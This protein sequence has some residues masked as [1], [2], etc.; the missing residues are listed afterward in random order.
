MAYSKRSYKSSGRSFSKGG[1]YA[2]PTRPSAIVLKV[3][4]ECR[5]PQQQVICQE[6]ASGAGNIAVPSVAG[7]GK[8]ELI[9][10]A[11]SDYYQAFP[12]HTV[13]FLAFQ[14]KIGDALLSRVP[15][16]VGDVRTVHGVGFGF[17]ARDSKNSQA[18]RAYS[19]MGD[20]AWGQGRRLEV[21][22][23]THSGG[24]KAPEHLDAFFESRVG[25]GDDAKSKRRRQ[26][27]VMG[28]ETA[29]SLCKTTLT[30]I[31]PVYEGEQ[32]HEKLVRL[33]RDPAG[34]VSL[35]DKYA[36]EFS[37]E[38]SADKA[39]EHIMAALEWN[40]NG[41]GTIVREYKGKR[42]EKKALT[43]GDM[44]WL[45][46]V[47][48]WELPRYDLVCVD[49][50]QDLSPA[51]ILLAV[52]SIKA[53]GRAL[54]VGDE[55]QSIFG[56]AGADC[57]ALPKLISRLDAKILP[58]TY[59]YRCPRAVVEFVRT[60]VDAA[61]PIEA[62]PTAKDG[63]VDEADAKSVAGEAKI[64]D[65][66]ISRTNAPLVRFFFQ[67]AKAGT[68]VN[69]LGREIGGQ[70]AWRLRLWQRDAMNAGIPWTV[71]ALLESSGAYYS[72]REERINPKNRQ[73]LEA[74]ADERETIKALCEGLSADADAS[75]VENRVKRLF[76]EN[77]NDTKSVLLASTH[78]FK[79]GERER[80]FL[81]WE[82]YKFA[83]DTGGE[84]ESNEM[85]QERNLAIVGATRSLDRLTLVTGLNQRSEGE[86]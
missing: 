84:H 72:A 36:V 85:R 73:A 46:L 70:I 1:S 17:P 65:A 19:I 37:D 15:P 45:P 22:G 31:V 43:F 18:H 20:P 7:S 14:K 25:A 28:L 42:E 77:E 40:L 26:Q 78:R 79:G 41:P 30:G 71:R 13:L 16:S 38:L 74:V 6:L 3:G 2:K 39:A 47:K 53:G 69:F 35:I 55:F 51:R 83:G 52:L 8:T 56:F 63:T 5:S 82:T 58:L 57:D 29:L 60:A 62:T 11:I 32:G 59:T 64:G 61:Y 24:A 49:E 34:V 66:I 50:A 44:L 54:V 23:D 4:V 86:G 9:L 48:G 67:L 81:L 10:H 12:Q 75:E 33:E 80:V 27:D 76:G 68:P 21:V